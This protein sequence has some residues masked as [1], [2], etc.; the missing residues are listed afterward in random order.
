MISTFEPSKGVTQSA[1]KKAPTRPSMA[2]ISTT[3]QKDN[4]KVVIR[5]RP[6]NEREKQGGPV[7]KVKLCLTVEKNTKIILDRGMD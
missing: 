7:E 6:V 3:A 2:A 1:R 4:V 5:V